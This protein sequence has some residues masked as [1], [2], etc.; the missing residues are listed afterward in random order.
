MLSVKL[1]F[2]TKSDY[3]FVEADRLCCKTRNWISTMDS[4]LGF[5][6][7]SDHKKQRKTVFPKSCLCVSGLASVEPCVVF[8]VS[9]SWLWL[10]TAERTLYQ[11]FCPYWAL[12]RLCVVLK[13]CLSHSRSDSM[14]QLAV[15]L[16]QIHT[17]RTHFPM[18]CGER[19]LSQRVSPGLLLLLILNPMAVVAKRNVIRHRD[20]RGCTLIW[21]ASWL[22]WADAADED[23][24]Q[25]KEQQM[26]HV[27][28]VLP[29][30]KFLIMLEAIL[31]HF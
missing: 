10:V 3:S 12:A 24:C 21:V 16:P 23:L 4:T 17:N 28:F 13:P 14:W 7:F 11:T 26:M 15:F 19:C 31:C 6:L 5:S 20:G 18:V 27:F 1:S 29:L 25:F 2:L 30:L 8:F 22:I 9:A